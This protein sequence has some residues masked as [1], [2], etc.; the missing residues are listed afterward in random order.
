[1]G[2]GLGTTRSP[3]LRKN[4]EGRKKEVEEGEEKT[5]LAQHEEEQKKEEKGKLE[6]WAVQGKGKE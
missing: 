4:E 2:H 5:G 3:A 1:L 6:L